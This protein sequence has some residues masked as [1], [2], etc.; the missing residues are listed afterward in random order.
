M[1]RWVG[2]FHH[3]TYPCL[4][5]AGLTGKEACLLR[6]PLTRDVQCRG[7]YRGCRQGR[8]QTQMGPRFMPVTISDGGELI[9][10]G[11]IGEVREA[12]R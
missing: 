11:A 4:A 9:Q 7:H 1:N 5:P 10:S 6:K 3:R 2:G 12:H 8:R